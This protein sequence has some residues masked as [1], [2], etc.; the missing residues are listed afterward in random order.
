MKNSEV[1]RIFFELAE[2]LE[3]KGEDYFKIRAYRHVARVLAGLTEPVEDI[4]RRGEL[5]KIPG[6]GKII[7]GKIREILTTGR[8]KK[9]MMNC[10]RKYLPGSWK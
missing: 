4:H 2:L 1:A 3:C 10:C 5:N 6:V 9:N 7:A 8:L